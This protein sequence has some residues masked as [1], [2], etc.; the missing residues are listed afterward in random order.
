MGEEERGKESGLPEVP[1]DWQS[2]IKKET[3]KWLSQSCS[4]IMTPKVDF[5]TST[6][7]QK[8][9]QQQKGIQ[10]LSCYVCRARNFKTTLSIN[11][12]W[13]I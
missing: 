6:I 4:H 13:C 10:H 2:W 7:E 5:Q 3:F 9:K 11:E 1:H 8:T 12:I